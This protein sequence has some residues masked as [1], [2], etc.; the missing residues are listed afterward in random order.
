[1]RR[2]SFLLVAAGL[3]LAHVAT[4]AGAGSG[5]PPAGVADTPY[6]AWLPEGC[7]GTLIAP[8]RVLTAGHCLEGYSPLG[9]SVLV[10]KDGNALIPFGG[11][12][13]AGAIANGGIPAAGFSIHPRFREA[14]PFAHRSPSN[15]I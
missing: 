9:F 4:P 12:R 8:D 6:V 2:T 11:D 10:G 15:A 13:F 1:M 5:G 3:G 7:T 14:F